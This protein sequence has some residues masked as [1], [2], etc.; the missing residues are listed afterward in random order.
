MPHE[1]LHQLSDQK[2]L[3][4]MCES[5]NEA[6]YIVHRTLELIEQSQIMLREL[7]N[8]GHRASVRQTSSIS[9]LAPPRPIP[10]R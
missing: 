1:E 6:R 4:T 10:Q 3:I 2:L 5:V 7:D 8:H 9:Y